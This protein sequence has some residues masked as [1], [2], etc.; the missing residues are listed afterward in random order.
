MVLLLGCPSQ[1][2][3][4]LGATRERL[5]RLRYGAREGWA[6]PAEVFAEAKRR[7]HEMARGGR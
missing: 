6:P 1:L 4:G 3:P 2:A 5:L 7:L